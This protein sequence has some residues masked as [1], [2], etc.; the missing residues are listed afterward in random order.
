VAADRLGQP[1][2]QR[3]VAD[4]GAAVVGVVTLGRKQRR[5]WPVPGVVELAADVGHE[6]CQQRLGAVD[7]RHHALL[8]T[9]VAVAL[10]EADVQLAERADVPLDVV[11]VE[12]ACLVD[13][14]SDLADQAGA[15]VVAGGDRELAG[16]ARLVPPAVEQLLDLRLL[17]GMRRL[18]AAPARGRF[19]SS[20]GDSTTRPVRL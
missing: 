10:A 14:Q 15:G 11:Q 7:Q 19:I 5:A 3:V 2:A 8:G 13:P 4:A 6:P 20:S 9:A 18:S 1:V 12:R 17:G 16:G